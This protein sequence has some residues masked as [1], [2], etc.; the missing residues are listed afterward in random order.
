[1]PGPGQSKPA[2][3]SIFAYDPSKYAQR[4]NETDIAYSFRNAGN[5][6]FRFSDAVI[7][8][9]YQGGKSIAQAA[10]ATPAGREAAL[11]AKTATA[12][13]TPTN[14]FP[15]AFGDSAYDRAE[16]NASRI[17][18]VPQDLLKAI[19]MR[20]ERSNA[21]AVSS[22][23]GR[24]PYQIIPGTAEGIKKNYGIDPL[25]N[26]DNAALGAAY[27]LREQ[28]GGRG[29][30][31]PNWADPMT[32]LRA[33]GGYFGGAAGAANPTS[34]TL[35]D[36]N[37]SVGQYTRNVLGDSLVNPFSPQYANAALSEIEKSRQAALTPQTIPFQGSPMPEVPEVLPIPK[38]DFGPSDAALQALKPVEFTLKEQENL[39]WKNF[40][41]G[42][43]QGMMSSPQG[44]GLGSF[45]L[46]L[47]GAALAGK[48]AS[49]DEIQ[50]RKDLY[51]TKLAKWQAAL[52]ENDFTKAQVMQREL[53]ADWQNNQNR[54]MEQYK[55]G[56]EV[57][58]KTTMPSV[59][60]NNLIFQSLDPKTGKGSVVV[61]PIDSLV[62]SA[63]AME[64]AN[65]YSQAFGVQNSANAQVAGVMNR[66]QGQIVMAQA[67]QILSDTSAS[68]Q[69]QAAAA[70]FGPLQAI[71]YAIDTGQIASVIGE[72]EAEG[73]SEEVMKT[74]G[75]Q[76]IYPDQK[77]YAEAFKKAAMG[78]LLAYTMQSPDTLEKL[79]ATMGPA[80]NI[81]EQHE[82][83]S[84]RDER[85]TV[86]NRGQRTSTVTYEGDE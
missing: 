86:N 57:W 54:T 66:V 26:P 63:Y 4:P 61:Q 23:G 29:A 40:W 49:L 25:S 65:V 13:A 75:G 77:G 53:M 5:L 39:R 84:R 67:G 27:V 41:S 2:A 17:T 1:M 6:P 73:L 14:V 62:N 38:T 52:Y 7:D 44:E 46:R 60:G 70:A 21:S 3:T 82:R 69:E 56:L 76:G 18:G 42:M 43:G 47:G 22:A 48:G 28:G 83:F 36:A 24:T 32:R 34:E 37:M 55:Q 15:E 30:D 31:G 45:F 59:S 16:A 9:V 64:R 19:R 11:K 50:Q 33:V 51:D 12:A 80:A 35:R 72:D 74:L 10:F 58:S 79:M 85:T 81:Y 20:G 8:Q 71:N 78:R 68:P